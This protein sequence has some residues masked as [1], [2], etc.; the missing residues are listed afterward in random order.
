M[1]TRITYKCKECGHTFKSSENGYD[2]GFRS[3]LFYMY[4]PVCKDIIS[5]PAW[6]LIHDLYPDKSHKYWYLQAIAEAKCPHCHTTAS[7][8]RCWNPVDFGCPKCRGELEIA[9]IEDW[10]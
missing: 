5:I 7:E 10:D 6:Y 8:L 2:C 3:Y 4:C 1:G 9:V